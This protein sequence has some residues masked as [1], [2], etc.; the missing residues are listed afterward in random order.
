MG[1]NEHNCAP[2]GKKT[3]TGMQVQ[4]IRCSSLTEDT[5]M[6]TVSSCGV[7]PQESG[8]PLRLGKKAKTLDIHMHFCGFSQHSF[9]VVFFLSTWGVMCK[10]ALQVERK[11]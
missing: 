7:K 4:I 5:S 10:T 9:I 3:V 11:R 8:G 6:I 1:C 2:S